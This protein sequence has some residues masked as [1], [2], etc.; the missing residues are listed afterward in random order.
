MSFYSPFTYCPPRPSVA[1]W[2]RSVREAI[3]DLREAVTRQEAAG[4]H[5]IAGMIRRGEGVFD[6]RKW[7]IRYRLN[8]YREA[9]R[10]ED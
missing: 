10:G 7:E 2:R 6:S 3:T 1:W 4:M 9:Q 5:D 8:R